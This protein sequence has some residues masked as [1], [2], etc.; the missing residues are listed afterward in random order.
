MFSDW[1]SSSYTGLSNKSFVYMVSARSVICK[2]LELCVK[3]Q[4]P[5]NPYICIFFW[6][7]VRTSK[8]IKIVEIQLDQAD[9]ISDIYNPF[10]KSI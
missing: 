7:V 3:I 1:Q 5:I 10:N 8:K 2:R 9:Y 4:H 6:Y